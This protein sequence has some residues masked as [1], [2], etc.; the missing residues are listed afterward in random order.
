MAHSLQYQI[1]QSIR[2]IEAETERLLNLAIALKEAGDIELAKAVLMQA[3]KL[4]EAAA[5]L[6]IAIAG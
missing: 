2:T 5:G 4:V 1:G 6:R 3:Q